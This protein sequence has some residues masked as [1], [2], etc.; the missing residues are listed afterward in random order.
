MVFLRNWIHILY[1]EVLGV[2]TWLH[3]LAVIPWLFHAHS[4]LLPAMPSCRPCSSPL[5]QHRVRAAGAQTPAP[6]RTRP[7]VTGYGRSDSEHLYLH[8]ALAVTERQNRL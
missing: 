2:S 5:H 7:R 4:Q 3:V 1:M 6:H 8:H